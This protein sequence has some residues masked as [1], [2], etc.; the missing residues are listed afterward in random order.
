MKPF[1]LLTELPARLE[2]R[3]SVHVRMLLLMFCRKNLLRVLISV[4]LL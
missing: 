4:A 3:I 2:V 1:N